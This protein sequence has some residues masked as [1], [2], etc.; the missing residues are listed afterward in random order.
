MYVCLYLCLY[1]C[2]HACM[3]VCMYVHSQPSRRAFPFVLHPAKTSHMQV[4]GLKP[5]M[6]IW[7]SPTTLYENMAT[8]C[9]SVMGSI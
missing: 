2:M 8:L 7:G 4:E 3:H 9:S 6:T 5:C 1:V